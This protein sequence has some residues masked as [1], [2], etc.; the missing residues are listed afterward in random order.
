[1][2]HPRNQSLPA[3][4]G[5]F[6]LPAFVIVIVQLGLVG[7]VAVALRRPG[8]PL[9]ELGIVAL[10]MVLV[11]P[12]AWEHYYLLA[13]PAWVVALARVEERAVGRSIALFAAGIATSGALTVWSGS[14]RGVLLEHSIY[15]WG[16]LA[17]LA[18]LIVD[19]IPGR[20]APDA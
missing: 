12:L 7:L 4:L 1:V 11:S 20:A 15:A 2:A 8:D 5:R 10:L 3:L 19:R 16:A 14:L 13:L 18:A 6:G 17:L 9:S